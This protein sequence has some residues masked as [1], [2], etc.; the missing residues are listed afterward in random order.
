LR[1]AGAAWYGTR[2]RPSADHVNE[3]ERDGA[4]VRKAPWI[5]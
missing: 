4:M 1:L 2:Q 3:T 5:R